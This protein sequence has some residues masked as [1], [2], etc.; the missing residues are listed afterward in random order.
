MRN[1]NRSSGQIL[2]FLVVSTLILVVLG[3]G[4]FFLIQIFG[5]NGEHRNATDSGILNLNKEAVIQSVPAN[6]QS[7]FQTMFCRSTGLKAVD[8]GSYN[9]LVSSAMI[10]ALN[11]SADGLDTGKANAEKVIVDLQR[12]NQSL[13]AKLK[14]L[15]GNP[16]QASWAEESFSKTA[17]ANSERMLGK[18][19]QALW[20]KD[21]Y[22]V[23]YLEASS[24]DIGASNVAIDKLLDNMPVVYDA[25]G[26]SGKN[27][28]IPDKMVSTEGGGKYMHGYHPISIP[29]IS[30]PIYAVP[31]QPQ[32]QPH[33]LSLHT[34][35]QSNQQPGGTSGVFL[36][37]NGFG[38]G[39]KAKNSISSSNSSSTAAGVVGMP[40]TDPSLSQARLPQGFL[41]ID[42]SM[43]ASMNTTIPNGDNWE[44]CEAG[45]G[46]LVYRPNHV[47][48]TESL[49]NGHAFNALNSW[50]QTPRSTD[51]DPNSGPP[52]MDDEGNAL[53]Y[54]SNG[55]PIATKADAARLIP[56]DTNSNN[57]VLATDLDSDPNGNNPDPDCVLLATPTLPDN[58]SP[59]NRAYHPNANSGGGSSNGRNL[60]ASEQAK[61]YALGL[62]GPQYRA[63][64]RGIYNR[65]FGL[66]GLR[67]Y[68]NSMLPNV[69]GP[70]PYAP[71]GVALPMGNPQRVPYGDPSVMGKI[72]T[73]GTIQELFQQT[74]GSPE[75]MPYVRI[76]N[77]S[78]HSRLVNKPEKITPFQEVQQF[79]IQR[80][81]EIKPTANNGDFDKV[82]QQK[83]PLGTRFYVYLKNPSD[84]NSEF[85]V[86]S[87]APSWATSLTADG[88]RHAFSVSYPIS[89]GSRDTG[90]MIDSPNDFGIHDHLFMTNRVYAS[91][92]DAVSYQSSSGSNGLLGYVKFIEFVKAS[93]SFTI[94]NL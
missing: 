11:A 59:F 85:T 71:A 84:P 60:I 44:A 35:S 23:A 69:G 66:T 76:D 12:S 74:T 14:N 63:G 38:G 50:L 16:D 72:T 53:L 22:M 34:F 78:S 6:P 7:E 52:I 47:F 4:F 90:Y 77:D 29:N 49:V 18:D 25:E 40:T 36:P 32:R 61:M 81:K 15:L 21:Q 80:M 33:L 91:A 3:L 45:T 48:S 94:P 57:V 10:V 37:P 62:Y 31:T 46:T 51:F 79:I 93:G 41:V 13:G 89:G 26:L 8:L 42:N 86:T 55:A 1:N 82:F 20:D 70:Y 92:T 2:P 17:M 54:D 87:A 56:Y 5:G 67:V 64:T 30:Y 24:S 27:L 83:L 65:N 58:L 75:T 19:A 88:K 28:Q 39:A 9:R 43:T 73:D 68:P